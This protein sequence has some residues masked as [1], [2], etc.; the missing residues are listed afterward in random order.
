ML[1]PTATADTV[2]PAADA[3]LLPAAAAADAMQMHAVLRKST[4]NT[5]SRSVRSDRMQMD[6]YC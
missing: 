2:L 6:D 4:Q 5:V 1:V 3:V